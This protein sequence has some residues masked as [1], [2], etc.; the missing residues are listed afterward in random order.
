MESTV[1]DHIEALKGLSIAQLRTRYRELFGEDHTTTHR[2][3]LVRRIAWRVQSL[4]EGGLSERARRRALELAGDSDLRV[5]IPRAQALH[6]PRRSSKR[7][8]RL[9]PAG[10]LLSRRYRDQTITVLV[11]EDGF[12]HEGE[13]YDSLSAVAAKVTGTRW[14]GFLFFG[15]ARRKALRRGRS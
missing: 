1:S 8:H 14:N 7:D 15:L 13:H 6:P 11:L 2:Q 10:T 5:L 9:P 4:A 12:E 3:V